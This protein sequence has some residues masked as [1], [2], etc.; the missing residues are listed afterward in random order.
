MKRRVLAA[1]ACIAIVLVSAMLAACDVYMDGGTAVQE[2]FENNLVK[3]GVYLADGN[4]ML[5]IKPASDV[6]EEIDHYEVSVFRHGEAKATLSFNVPYEDK[7]IEVALYIQRGLYNI[8]VVGVHQKADSSFIVVCKGSFKGYSLTK[9]GESVAVELFDVGHD[10]VHYERVSPTCEQ[11][12]NIE[13]WYCKRCERNFQD[14]AGTTA[15]VGSVVLRKLHPQSLEKVEA[16][17]ATCT[18]EGNVE[19]WKCPVCGKWYSDG[20]GES[21]IA[22]KA[23]VVVPKLPHSPDAAWHHDSSCPDQHWHECSVCGLRVGAEPHTWGGGVVSKEPTESEQGELSYACTV[24]GARKIELIDPTGEHEWEA[25]AFDSKDSTCTEDGYS[26]YRCKDCDAVKIV[27]IKALGHGIESFGKV[28]AGCEN[29]GHKAYWHCRRCDKYFSDAGL[30]NEMTW[31]ELVIPANGHRSDTWCNDGETGNGHWKVC[32]ECGETFAS[33]EHTLV[34]KVEETYLNTPASCTSPASYFKSCETCGWASSETFEYGT[35]TGHVAVEVEGSEPTCT[36]EGV[37]H[38]WHCNNCGVNFEDEACT[39]PMAKISIEKTPHTFDYE[40]KSYE[41]DKET[42]LYHSVKCKVCG[43]SDGNWTKH[44]SNNPRS[45]GRNDTHHWE[46][47]VCGYHLTEDKEHSWEFVGGENVC[48]VCG[49]VADDDKTES[50]GFDVDV[51]NPEP[52][53]KLKWKQKGNVW[54]FEFVDERVGTSAEVKRIEWYV[55]GVKQDETS[56]VFELMYP[57]RRSYTVMCIFYN[58][59]SAAS[60]DVTITGTGERK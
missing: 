21:L 38:H 15:I 55:N 3:D 17:D 4:G 9:A 26:K 5:A 34:E 36:E 50:S 40:G 53:G 39:K 10:M 24:C 28:A 18:S 25:D 42:G 19:Y 43:T 31:E 2:V 59:K 33:G 23:D 6:P 13:Y 20:L 22:D 49:R 52:E 41:I 51:S 45:Y 1:I 7:E 56:N 60:R 47:C 48:S 27:V 8:E 44:A 46:I 32:E 29:E 54:T 11:D 30:A 35:V 58:S 57:E 16:V 37:L 14:E 12:G